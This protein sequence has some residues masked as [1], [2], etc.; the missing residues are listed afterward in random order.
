MWHRRL[1]HPSFYLL[2][3]LFPTLVPNK[4]IFEISCEA[5]ELGKH[6]RATFHSSLNK[7]TIP[8]SLMHTDVWG[9]SHIPTFNDYKWL[10]SFIDDCTRTTWVYLMKE[11]NAV[12]SILKVFHK[13]ICTQFNTV[14]KIVRSDKGGEYIYGGLSHYFSEHGM[15]HQTSCTNTPQ[16]YGVAERKNRH[17]L[18]LARSI[19]FSM[20]VPK[21]YWG[22][23]V[24]TA[25][26]LI[27]RLPTRVL[28]KKS[29]VE[30]LTQSFSLFPIPP[31]VFGCVCFVHNHSPVRKKL[32][33]RAIKCVFLGYSPTQKGYK[34]YHPPSRKWYVSMDVTF[35]EH[36]SYFQPSQP[37]LQ[38]RVS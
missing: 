33:P 20:Q 8:F 5:C 12:F 25:A 21:T 4:S 14:V 26:Y 15:I 28:G 2:H 10:V 24:L 11:K 31:K 30:L 23:A 27:N 17:L 34:C 6:H 29:P 36:S 3:F 19:M 1:G 13:M 38:G 22:E 35:D 9:P 37:S 32:D 16:Q 7:S 18:E